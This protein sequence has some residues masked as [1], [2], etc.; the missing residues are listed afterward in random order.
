M[1]LVTLNMHSWLESYQIP[2]LYRIADTILR[3]GVDVIALQEVNQYPETPKAPVSPGLAFSYF[4]PIREDNAAHLLVRI[5]RAKEPETPWSWVWVGT[6][7]GFDTYDEGLAL[8]SRTPIEASRDLSHGGHYL[9]ED[10]RRR[11]TAAIRTQGRWVLSSHFSWW[12]AFRREW[13][14]LRP[15]LA[16][17]RAEGPVIIAGDFNNPASAVG[18][19]YELVAA[20][21]WR[22]SYL[23]ARAREGEATVHRVIDGWDEVGESLRIDYV[24]CTPDLDPLSYRVLFR[25]DTDHAVS[26]HSGIL[27]EIS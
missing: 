5:L 15:Q 16:E 11:R 7:R 13:E 20:D 21:G 17:L 3:E 8:I 22:D 24:W 25:D 4:R 23:S 9:W 10:H 6:H 14:A 18:E 19:G 12:P 27:V 26:D 1:K 2:K